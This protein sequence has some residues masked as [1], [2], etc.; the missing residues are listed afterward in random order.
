METE[1][2]KRRIC[3]FC[4]SRDGARRSYGE[5]A[6][7][8]GRELAGR[9][10]G[11][12]YGGGRVGLMGRVADAALAAGGEVQ[13]VIPRSMVDREL[14][15]TG[16]TRLHIVE[17]MHQRKALMED[18]SDGFIV[19]PG[20]IGTLEEVTEVLSWA[21]L[22]IH[23]KP[24]GL[25]NVQGY[26]DAL[27]ALLDHAVAEGFYRTEHRELLLVRNQIGPLVDTVLGHA[28]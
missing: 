1:N 14:A 17:T 16:L 3:V 27:T 10:V 18:L 26:F 19:L 11:L 13:G 5:A 25:L 7:E 4:G 15:H 23:R 9:G 22:S 12:V 6:V 28:Y 8:L 21:S 20:G 2:G 24:C